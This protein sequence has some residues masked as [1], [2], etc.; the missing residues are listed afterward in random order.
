MADYNIPMEEVLAFG[1]NYNDIPLLDEVGYGVA[2]AN[3]R[4]E[5]KAVAKEVTSSNIEDGVAKIIE[6]LLL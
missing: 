6:K 4:E 5:V 3:A 1:D 2:V